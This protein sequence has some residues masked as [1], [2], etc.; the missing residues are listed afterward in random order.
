MAATVG[1]LT[2]SFYT[3]DFALVE[4]PQRFLAV[5]VLGETTAILLIR[6]S[7]HTPSNTYLA[8][9]RES[10]KGHQANAVP[11]VSLPYGT[12]ACHLQCHQSFKLVCAS[13]AVYMQRELARSVR[14]RRMG[15]AALYPSRRPSVL[16]ERVQ[17]PRL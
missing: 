7:V 14:R 2:S 9:S 6:A 5:S 4:R 10:V 13:V 3:I 15:D 16:W 1:I 12:R 17:A 8:L 11:G